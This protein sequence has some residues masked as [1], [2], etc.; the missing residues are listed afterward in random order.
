M[1]IA[2]P[3]PSPRVT[4]LVF[5]VAVGLGVLAAAPFEDTIDVLGAPLALI[6]I[7]LLRSGDGGASAR[8]ETDRGRAML[9]LR[10]SVPLGSD[11]YLSRT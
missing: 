2:L 5:C 8:F 11:G 3:F 9:E 6:A 4:L 1:I 7:G 10:R